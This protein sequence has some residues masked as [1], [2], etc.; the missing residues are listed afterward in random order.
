MG[1][2]FCRRALSLA[3]HVFHKR[4][5]KLITI[6][7]V[8]FAVHVLTPQTITWTSKHQNYSPNNHNFSL[9]LCFTIRCSW[10]GNLS[11]FMSRLLVSVATWLMSVA[12]KNSLTIQPRFIT[13]TSNDNSHGLNYFH[14]SVERKTLQIRREHHT[15]RC[16]LECKLFYEY[17]HQNERQPTVTVR[18]IGKYK[19][20][21][22]NDKFLN[23]PASFT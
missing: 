21:V 20:N 11:R 8:T 13:I 6:D 16:D 12:D 9:L 17:C 22:H 7:L 3:A 15:Y 18:V 5:K 2:S 19:Y 1:A 23:A 14:L 4:S 10:F